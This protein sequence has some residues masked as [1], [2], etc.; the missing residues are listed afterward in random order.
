MSDVNRNVK[1]ILCQRLNLFH[2]QP[3][4]VQTSTAA[5]QQAAATA[6]VT[7]PSAPAVTVA[8][9]AAP[10]SRSSVAH[11]SAPVTAA[12][13]TPS[14]SGTPA[15]SNLPFRG[16]PVGGGIFQSPLEAVGAPP[17]PPIPISRSFPTGS[18][19]SPTEPRMFARYGQ[20]YSSQIIFLEK[21]RMSFASNDNRL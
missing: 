11:P 9:S 21:M 18:G 14:L 12:A 4:T 20:H 7:T 16:L 17:P 10:S 2:Q 13:V 6:L 1:Y 19:S 3:N 5:P 15:S 8:S